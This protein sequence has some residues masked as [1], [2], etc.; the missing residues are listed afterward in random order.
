MT[1]NA[2]LFGLIAASLSAVALVGIALVG[3]RLQRVSRPLSIMAGGLLLTLVAFHIA[4]EALASSR[5]APMMIAGGFVFAFLLQGALKAA[6]SGG[7]VRAVERATSGGGGQGL[8]AIV[9][10]SPLVAIA[11]HSFLDGI[12][13]GVTFAGS[14]SSGIYTATALILHEVPEAFVAFALVSAAG[15]SPA[16]SAMA[17]FLAAGLTTPLG[18]AVS[19]S[20]IA[21][22]GPELVP[23][24]FA[25]SAG[26]LLYV[27]L[28]ALLAP[29][30]SPDRHDEGGLGAL[31]AGVAA[32]VILLVAPLPHTH[33]GVDHEGHAVHAHAHDQ[34][35]HE[36]H[37]H[38]N[39]SPFR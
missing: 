4:P 7:G 20:V 11:L 6:A 33:G 25:L 29:L 3:A 28:G 37:Q 31:G 13:Y 5:F 27:A 9:A 14:F 26:L 21:L 15:F 38:P 17:A 23:A 24:L 16:R 1:N 39:F 19:S 32:G 18:A 35:G 22:L 34:A 12:I 36:T 2:I 10:L 8:S 30:Y